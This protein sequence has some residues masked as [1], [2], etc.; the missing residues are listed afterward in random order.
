MKKNYFFIGL[1]LL[2]RIRHLNNLLVYLYSLPGLPGLPG[3]PSLIIGLGNHTTHSPSSSS[4]FKAR[5][6]KLAWFTGPL[7]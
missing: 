3:L 6:P 7:N 5:P 2:R 1:T 4:I